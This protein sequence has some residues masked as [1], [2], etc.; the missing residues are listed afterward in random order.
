MSP[1]AHEWYHL[2][3]KLNKT[4]FVYLPLWFLVLLI[5]AVMDLPSLDLLSV[6]PTC[7]EH[8]WLTNSTCYTFASSGGSPGHISLGLFPV[9]DWAHQ[10]YY[11]HSH[12]YQIRASSKGQQSQGLPNNLA[13]TFL[14]ICCMQYD[15][16]PTQTFLPFLL[17]HSQTCT[18]VWKVSLLSTKGVSPNKSLAETK[19][20]S[21]IWFLEH[22]KLKP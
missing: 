18:A 11:K 15:A 4:I 3:I 21:G 9:N 6:E 12:S 20:Y 16:L 19:S 10:R 1:C 14:G 13:E 5:V 22:S 2:M 8:S 17:P 7:R